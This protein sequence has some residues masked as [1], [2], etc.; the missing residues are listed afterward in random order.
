M[1][2]NSYRQ[3]CLEYSFGMTT[4]SLST[5]NLIRRFFCRCDNTKKHFYLRFIFSVHNRSTETLATAQILISRFTDA[6]TFH[7]YTLWYIFD[8]IIFTALVKRK[9]DKDG[10]RVDALT[11]VTLRSRNTIRAVGDATIGYYLK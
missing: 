1:I 9:T 10:G 2:L 8:Y 6:R 7:R 5:S 4:K 11:P 3:N